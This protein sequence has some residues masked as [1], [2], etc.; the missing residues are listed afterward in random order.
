MESLKEQFEQDG[1]VVIRNLLTPSEIADYRAKLQKQSGIGDKDFNEKHARMKGWSMPDGVTRLRDWWPIIFNHRLVAAM[2]EILGPSARYTQ[3][4]DLHVHHG[5]VGWHRDS[6]D[7]KLGTGPDWDES[8]AP[9]QVARVAIYLQSYAESESS[10]GVVAGSHRNETKA[11]FYEI[12]LHS[13]IKQWIKRPDLLFP[14]LTV[15]PTWIK[16]EPGDC[17]IFNQRILHTGSHIRGPKY[18]IF[19]SYG[20]DNEHSR[21]HRRYYL[22]GRSELKYDDFQPELAK[23]LEQAGLLLPLKETKKE[24]VTA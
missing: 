4:S 23:Q 11:T 5:A 24:A 17:L 16:T 14:L 15:R 6:V 10:L 13:K 8:R 9:Y 19:L 20:A 2:R 22:F 3:H 1:F 18:A 21:N 12:A 7:R